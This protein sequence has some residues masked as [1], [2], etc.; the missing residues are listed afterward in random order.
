MEIYISL[1][2][3]D[4]CRET[5]YKK[6]LSLQRYFESQGHKVI[7]PFDIAKQV[8]SRIMSMCKREPTHEEYMYEDLLELEWCSHIFLCEGWTESKGCMIEVNKAIKLGLGFFTELT[9]KFG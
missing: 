2:I 6:A 7:N 1:P 5:Q 9:Y 8:E 4:K 3:T